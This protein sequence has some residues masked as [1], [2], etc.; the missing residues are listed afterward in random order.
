MRKLVLLWWWNE[1]KKTNDL[2]KWLLYFIDSLNIQKTLLRTY[3]LDDGPFQFIALLCHVTTVMAAG[4]STTIVHPQGQW[5]L[6]NTLTNTYSNL[7]NVNSF[8]LI[9]MMILNTTPTKTEMVE[10]PPGRDDWKPQAILCRDSVTWFG[11]P[12]WRGKFKLL[13]NYNILAQIDK[14]KLMCKAPIEQGHS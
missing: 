3:Y 10:T 9:Q 7:F 6:K 14:A 12:S 5:V 2:S 13:L 4:Q 1:K 8:Y 11:Q